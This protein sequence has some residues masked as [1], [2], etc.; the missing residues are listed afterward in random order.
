MLE[1]EIHRR[2]GNFGTNFTKRKRALERERGFFASVA[3]E[4]RKKDR[5]FQNFNVGALND[6]GINVDHLGHDVY[7]EALA[8]QIEIIKP[9][10]TIGLFARWGSGKSFLLQ[11]VQSKWLGHETVL[12]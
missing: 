6:N 9:P 2:Q 1:E 4:A 11:H 8:N 5:I 7:A 10:L 12:H 3:L